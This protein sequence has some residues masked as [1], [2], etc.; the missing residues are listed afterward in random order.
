[1]T[2]GRHPLC[3]SHCHIGDISF[4]HITLGGFLCSHYAWEFPFVR[5]TLRGLLCV[6]HVGWVVT[7]VR[8]TFWE[9]SLFGSH[10][11]M[12]LCKSCGGFPG[13]NHV[14]DILCVNHVGG[15]NCGGAGGDPHKFPS[16]KSHWGD[17]SHIT[18]LS[19]FP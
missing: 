12:P 11:G 8:F 19:L 13:V 5:I 1:M 9:F 6:Y 16:R 10:W 18:S 2:L 3:Q 4:V 7:F 15:M 14:G 17:A